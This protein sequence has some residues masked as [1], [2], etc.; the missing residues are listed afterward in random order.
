MMGDSSPR[1]ALNFCNYSTPNAG[2]QGQADAA[3]NHQVTTDVRQLQRISAPQAV[4]RK[5]KKKL[6]EA[7]KPRRRQLPRRAIA[8]ISLVVYPPNERWINAAVSGGWER[9]G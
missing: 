9:A 2:N 6:R 5:L 8:G 4:F 3:I 7:Q 1:A